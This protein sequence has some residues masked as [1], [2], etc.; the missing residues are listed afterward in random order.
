[1]RIF[2]LAVDWSLNNRNQTLQVYSSSVEA[3]LCVG[4][5]VIVDA[6]CDGNEVAGKNLDIAINIRGPRK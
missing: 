4:G 6:F 5:F 3:F 1:M 2:S